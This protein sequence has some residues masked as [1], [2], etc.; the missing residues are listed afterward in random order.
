M[1]D[2]GLELIVGGIRDPQFGPVVKFGLGG[3]FAAALKDVAFR[4]APLA[5]EEALEMIQ[6]IRGAELLKGFRGSPP[7]DANAVAGTI[8][9]LGDL[10][11]AFEDVAEIEFNPLLAYPDAPPMIADVRVVLS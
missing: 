7:V 11:T 2:P 4:L 9:R 3:V 10:L 6:E 8:C 1:A 5:K